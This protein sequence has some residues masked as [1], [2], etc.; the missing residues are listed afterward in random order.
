MD[1]WTLIQHMQR[2][3]RRVQARLQPAMGRLGLNPSTA[4]L[5]AAVERYPHPSD[6][7]Q[8]LSLPAPTVSRL[9]KDLEAAGYLTRQTVPE[10]L[11]RFRLALTPQGEAIRKAAKEELSVAVEAMLRRLAPEDRETL[12]RLMAALTEQE[13]AEADGR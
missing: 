12:D 9:L 10:D 4:F 11:R 5:L 1:S 7:A 13:E 6:L 8:E 2:F 3:H